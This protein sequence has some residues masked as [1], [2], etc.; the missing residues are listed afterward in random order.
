MEAHFLANHADRAVRAVSRIKVPGNIPGKLLAPSLLAIL[1][2]EVEQQQRFPMQLVQDLCR[3]LEKES[4]KFFKRD[5]KATFVCRTR[6][7]FIDDESHLSPRL[8]S[9][10]G[11]VRANPGVTVGKLVSTLAPHI[12]KP[13][14]KSEAPKAPAAE[15]PVT[16]E[17][18]PDSPV[19]E[20]TAT[21]PV[22]P[23]PVESPA[24]EASVSTNETLT[25][26]EDAAPTTESIAEGEIETQ[27]VAAGATVAVGEAAPEKPA[28][29]AQQGR[30]GR[31][32]RGPKNQRNKKPA[33]VPEGPPAP[34]TSEEIGVLQDL[35]WLVQE[36]LVTE[37]ATGEL[38]ILGR[39][40]QPPAEKK[41]RPD[42]KAESAPA[43]T[44][45]PAS[46][47]TEPAAA[48]AAEV[49]SPAEAAAETPHE[50]AVE[51]VTAEAVLQD[52]GNPLPN[53]DPA[54]AKSEATAPTE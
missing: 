48:P 37:F 20:S 51:I 14:T 4:L 24:A 31:E 12:E 7:H 32:G 41:P 45:G 25:T 8:R 42:P 10:V 40:P 21:A 6:P 29:P 3:D 44:N 15:T 43:K 11:V 53:E 17:P 1:R 18:T 13:A 30:E 19:S 50:A 23:A 46:A 35:R 39:P 34:L 38:Q 2:M 28:A 54:P 49:E 52:E 26:P 22:D 5:K 9:I 36:G 16:V 47:E 27:T 33:P